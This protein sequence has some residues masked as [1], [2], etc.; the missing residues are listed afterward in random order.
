MNANLTFVFPQHTE[1]TIF[2]TVSD[3]SC[4]LK[5]QVTKESGYMIK[6]RRT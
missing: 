5:E 4:N 6:Q 3:R 2:L 1:M